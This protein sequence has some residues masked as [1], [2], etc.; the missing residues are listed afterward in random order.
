MFQCWKDQVRYSLKVARNKAKAT[1]SEFDNSVVYTTENAEVD[2][3]MA[4]V[5]WGL[6]DMGHTVSSLYIPPSILSHFFSLFLHD[7]L[8]C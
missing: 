1:A 7:T 8:L 2:R 6:A 4:L 3:V 5:G